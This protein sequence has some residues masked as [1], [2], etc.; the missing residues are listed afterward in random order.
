[1]RNQVCGPSEQIG[2][3]LMVGQWEGE[4]TSRRGLPA[5]YPMGLLPEV[6]AGPHE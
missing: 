2:G 6:A 4:L 1:M 3:V 5:G